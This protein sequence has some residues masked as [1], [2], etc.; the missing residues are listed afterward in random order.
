MRPTDGSPAFTASNPKSLS[1]VITTRPM[2]TAVLSTAVSGYE[3]RSGRRGRAAVDDGQL[4]HVEVGQRP[5][6]LDQEDGACVGVML[7]E[8]A[9]RVTT[10]EV[11][12]PPIDP[13][14]FRSACNWA[15]VSVLSNVVGVVVA[16]PPNAAGAANA[17]PNLPVIAGLTWTVSRCTSLRVNPRVPLLVMRQLAGRDGGQA[18]VSVGPAQHQF[19]EAALEQL[20][21]RRSS[22][23]SPR[24]ALMTISRRGPARSAS[25][26]R[27]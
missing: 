21:A 10:T 5:Q 16:S 26:C 15:A 23:I 4:A 9:I 8:G 17:R 22:G 20:V 13:R 7:A 3:C 25:G 24:F 27:C 2:T 12:M 1:C 18:G 19:A 6:E 14:A 11:P